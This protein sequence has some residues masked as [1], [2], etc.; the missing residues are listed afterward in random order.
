[1]K[2]KNLIFNFPY[3]CLFILLTLL[4]QCHDDELTNEVVDKDGNVYKTIKIG[5]Q[6]WIAENLKTI[7]YRNGDPIPLIKDNLKWHSQINGACCYYNNDSI[8]GKDYGVLYNYYAIQDPRNI[9]P[10]GYHV[11]TDEDWTKLSNFIGGLSTAGGKLKEIGFVH[12]LTPNSG[13]TNEIGF[14]C[15]GGGYRD[16]SGSFAGLGMFCAFWNGTEFV[17]GQAIN[18]IIYSNDTQMTR[19]ISNLGI[20]GAGGYVRIV[21]D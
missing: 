1:M 8:L 20:N 2:N 7:T 13:A 18:R 9:A 10:Q 3:L 12:W 5:E 14:N 4:I 15:R 6:T 19:E 16:I 11:A 17:A 21:K